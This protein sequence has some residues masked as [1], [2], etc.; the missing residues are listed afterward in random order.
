MNLAALIEIIYFFYLLLII[1]NIKRL[2]F[3][4]YDRNMKDDFIQDFNK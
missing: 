4:Y 3:E 2:F 1:I